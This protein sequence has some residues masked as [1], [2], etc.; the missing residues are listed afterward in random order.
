MRISTNVL[1]TAVKMKE[2]GGKQQQGRTLSPSQ[3]MEKHANST[4]VCWGACSLIRGVPQFFSTSLLQHLIRVLLFST[5]T[6]FMWLVPPR[7]L[8]HISNQCVSFQFSSCSPFLSSNKQFSVKFWGGGGGGFY[9]NQ[10]S[11]ELIFS[12]LFYSLSS[13]LS[14]ELISLKT[15][16]TKI[17][18][19]HS[20]KKATLQRREKIA[21]LWVN[22]SQFPSVYKKD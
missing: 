18:H 4:C 8:Q 15:I 22:I 14:S 13:L 11:T 9:H 12:L 3:V 2:P 16:F 10:H 6:T 5:Q 20:D 21:L 1:V 19:H 17:P 7:R